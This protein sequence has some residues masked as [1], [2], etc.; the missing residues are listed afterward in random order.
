MVLAVTTATMGDTMVVITSLLFLANST[1]LVTKHTIQN[2]CQLLEVTGHLSL[3]PSVPK[4]V[5]EPLKCLQPTEEK[6]VGENRLRKDFA[7]LRSA[8]AHPDLRV[9]QARTEFQEET[10][11]REPPELQEEE[12]LQGP[13]VPMAL[14]GHQGSTGKMAFQVHLGLQELLARMVPEGFLENR[15]FQDPKDL[16]EPLDHVE[17]LARRALKDLLVL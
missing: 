15:E 10:E 5:R 8:K 3:L 1:T 11:T 14:L 4:V 2:P 9:H 7:S 12:D 13:L 6:V 16:R 17:G